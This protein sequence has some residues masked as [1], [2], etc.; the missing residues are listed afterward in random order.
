MNVGDEV[1]IVNCEG[2]PKV[3]GKTVKVTGI[4][5]VDQGEGIGLVGVGVEVNYGRGRPQLGRPTAFM[6]ADVVRIGD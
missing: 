3:V 2:C 5:T 4:K 6:F 1:R